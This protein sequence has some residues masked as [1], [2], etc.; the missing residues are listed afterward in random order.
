[1]KRKRRIMMMKMKI[2]NQRVLQMFRTKAAVETTRILILI[3][4]IVIMI[5]IVV[6]M[7]MIMMIILIIIVIIKTKIIMK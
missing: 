3:I 6:F 7:I 4:I 5:I 2:Y 1:M